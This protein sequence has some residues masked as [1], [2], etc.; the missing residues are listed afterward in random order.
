M[1]NLQLRQAI[2]WF[3]LLWLACAGWAPAQAG[4]PAWE[5]LATY[6]LPGG[7]EGGQYVRWRFEVQE[8][9]ARSDGLWWRVSVRDADGRTPVEGSF[10]LNPRRGLIA[11]VQVRE[12]YQAAWHEYPLQQVEP[13]SRYFHAFGPLPLDFV[14]RDGLKTDGIQSF[15]HAVLQ[16]LEG[17]HEFRREYGIRSEPLPEVPAAVR[18]SGIGKIARGPCLTLRIE[19][20]F[21]PDSFRWMTWDARLPWWVEYRCPAYTASLVG[22]EGETGR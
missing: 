9:L 13:A 3:A 10:L 2:C 8:E 5:I 20:S 22:W 12:F 11:A 6:R 18:E 15:R 14:G 21:S 16:T 7:D 17:P 1:Q 4:L 19:D